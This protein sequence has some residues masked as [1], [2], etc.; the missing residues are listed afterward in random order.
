[1][2][3]IVPLLVALGLLVTPAVADDRAPVTAGQGP[4]LYGRLSPGMSAGDVAAI[5]RRPRLAAAGDPVTT[6]LLWSS[7]RGG[8]GTPRVPGD[9][10]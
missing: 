2:Q 5:A 9:V 4:V 10:P 8:V 3:S 1:M 6:W 7:P